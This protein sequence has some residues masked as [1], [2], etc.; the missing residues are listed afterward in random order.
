MLKGLHKLTFYIKNILIKVN[1]KY[2]FHIFGQLLKK[3]E[4][5]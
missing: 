2:I 5:L 3:L 1:L 4:I